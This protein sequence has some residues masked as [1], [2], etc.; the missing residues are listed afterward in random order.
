MLQLQTVRAHINQFWDEKR[1]SW[2]M[3]IGGQDLVPA[4][5]PNKIVHE[6]TIAFQQTE[7]AH[8]RDLAQEVV[9]R[10][11][12]S[13]EPHDIIEAAGRP[14]WRGIDQSFDDFAQNDEGDDED[15]DVEVV[16]PDGQCCG[17]VF[18]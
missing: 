5:N 3:T 18:A 7:A 11:I 6:A 10:K 8:D 4:V 15:L 13:I 16:W 14:V 1:G 17:V 12:E 2:K 9:E